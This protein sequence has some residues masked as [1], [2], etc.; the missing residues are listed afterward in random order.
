[1]L[2]LLNAFKLAL[3]SGTKDEITY[4]AEQLDRLHRQHSSIMFLFPE[5]DRDIIEYAGEWL[6]AIEDQEW[7]E[8]TN[9]PLPTDGS[10]QQQAL[11]VQLINHGGI[12][13]A[14]RH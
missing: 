9:A 6:K 10:L 1:M 12:M 3:K 8:A 11:L 7:L 2:H 13:P 5:Q 4:A 14:R